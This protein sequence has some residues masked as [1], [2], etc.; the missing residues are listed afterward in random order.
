[1]E[2]LSPVACSSPKRQRHIWSTR[3]HREIEK[4]RVVDALPS[5]ATLHRAQISES[6]GICESEFYC[7]VP[8]I[9]SSV[10]LSLVPRVDLLVIMPFSEKK[11]A[12]GHVQ[13]P[14]QAPKVEIRYGAI[15]LP[16]EL[17]ERKAL[18]AEEKE[19][20]F[21]LKLSLLQKWSPSTTLRMLVHEFFH[22]IQQ[23]DPSPAKSPSIKKA[24]KGES[25]YNGE[26]S[27]NRMRRSDAR[28]AIF[29]CR[30]VDPRTSTLKNTPMLL[31]SGY[32][33]LLASSDA[34]MEQKDSDNVYIGELIH[35]KDIV[36]ITPHGGKSITFFFKDRQ[37]P[38]RTFLSQHT[39][40]IMTE[41]TRRYQH[42]AEKYV[43]LNNKEGFV[44]R[45]ISEL[46]IFIEHP[47]AQ[48]ILVH[49]HAYEQSNK[50]IR[51]GSAENT[52]LLN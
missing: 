38:C 50:G 19:P 45:A 32:I 33:A 42:I 43:H 25:D 3:V 40:E 24:L 44:E 6:R 37:L 11:L 34:G 13:Y 28:G 47:K 21:T 15:Y 9:N 35:L 23:R 22:Q 16:V 2:S 49:A 51:V 36:R 39:D 7:F 10:A 17:R 46:Q 29:S 52:T 26:Q 14:F 31:Q 12:D 27:Y 4:C 48:R 1:M 41:I 30:E 5:G 20:T 8:F 18:V